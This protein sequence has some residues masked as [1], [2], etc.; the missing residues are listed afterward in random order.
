[1]YRTAP[2]HN[3]HNYPPITAI[4]T[5]LN[6]IREGKNL[7]LIGPQRQRGKEA[8]L[9]SCISQ[10]YLPAGLNL[11]VTQTWSYWA[12]ESSFTGDSL[13]TCIGLQDD[14]E[15]VRKGQKPRNGIMQRGSCSRVQMMFHW[16]RHSPEGTRKGW[17]A[18]VRKRDRIHRWGQRN[19]R[20]RKRVRE[21]I[22]EEGRKNSAGG[23]H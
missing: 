17:Q 14:S 5:S 13:V 19:W 20:V 22:T 11:G 18:E 21:I 8:R 15:R 12:K 7:S 1:M 4:T 6:R 10:L 16:C 2:C 23:K 3:H 9:Q